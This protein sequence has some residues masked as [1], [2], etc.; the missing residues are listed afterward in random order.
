M[1]PRLRTLT[2]IHFAITSGLVM[3]L[4]VFYMIGS[5]MLGEGAP[6]P[7]AT[8]EGLDAELFVPLVFLMAL[9][10]AAASF[11]LPNIIASKLKPVVGDSGASA[12]YQPL[13][14]AELEELVRQY[15]QVKIVQWALLDGPGLFAGAVFFLTG[16]V[17]VLGAGAL[18]IALLLYFRASR[19]DLQQ[20]F[21]LSD[22]QL[23]DF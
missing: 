23:A 21:G 22:Q 6:P 9:G 5:G 12:G 19:A 3:V 2:I 11:F 20:R 8:D 1:H 10:G 16:R 7:S 18:M 13:G 15:Q 4:A 14:A 17:E